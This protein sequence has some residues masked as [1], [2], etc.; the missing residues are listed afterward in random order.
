[1]AKHP[2]LNIVKGAVIVI[3]LAL[4]AV[5]FDNH[6]IVSQEKQACVSSVQSIQKINK[7]KADYKTS[8]VK[9][10]IDDTEPNVDNV[11]HNANQRLKS[12]INRLFNRRK[13][14]NQ[15]KSYLTNSV[16]SQMVSNASSSNKVLLIDIGYGEF[17]T[18]AKNIPVH[19]LVRYKQ[20]KQQRNVVYILEFKPQQSY[21][22]QF[23]LLSYD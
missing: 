3:S 7:S 5:S 20:G 4:F 19:V 23:A 13:N 8:N 2:V 18:Q 15:A 11:Q 6:K 10:Q 17:D 1:M 22:K 21:N 12:G 14:Y 9:Q 16:Y